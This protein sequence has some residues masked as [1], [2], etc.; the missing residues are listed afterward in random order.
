[1]IL[2]VSM[3][4]SG[5]AAPQLGQVLSAV[6]IVEPQYS[7]LQVDAIAV[8][9]FPLFSPKT[10]GTGKFPSPAFLGY[11]TITLVKT[12]QEVWRNRGCFVTLG[13]IYRIV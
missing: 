9:S 7:H 6:D 10:V 1:M 13:G 5:L 2:S 8:T 4:Y 3:T 12:Q 11:Y